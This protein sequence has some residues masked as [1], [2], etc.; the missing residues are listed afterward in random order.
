M[1]VIAV[2]KDPTTGWSDVEPPAG[3]FRGG[4]L[5]SPTL[6]ERLLRRL[7][8]ELLRFLRAFH[9]HP[10]SSLSSTA[11]VGATRKP[12]QGGNSSSR[13]GGDPRKANA[14]AEY[15]TEPR[16]CPSLGP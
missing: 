5:F 1:H 15:R 6:L 3:L 4:A 13:T 9:L 11:L 8:S 16:A 14:H 12:R 2:E 7:L 10:P